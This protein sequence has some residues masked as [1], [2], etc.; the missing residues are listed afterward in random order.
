MTEPL[1]N[2][3]RDRVEI[4][5]GDEKRHGTYQSIIMGSRDIEWGKLQGLGRIIWSNGD[6]EEGAYVLGKP[7]GLNRKIT[8]DRVIVTFYVGGEEKAIVKFDHKFKED[9]LSKGTVIN[10]LNRVIELPKPDDWRK[11]LDG[12]A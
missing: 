8:K 6:V 1:Y 12:T 11:E 10:Q 3:D 2:S 4:W 7:V 9:K 5:Q